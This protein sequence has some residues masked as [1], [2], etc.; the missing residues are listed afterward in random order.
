[1]SKRKPI[2]RT[3]I[4]CLMRS[5]AKDNDGGAYSRT[6]PRPVV[7]QNEPPIIDGARRFHK[8]PQA[9]LE[10]LTGQLKWIVPILP[11]EPGRRD[12]E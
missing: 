8:R 12:P 7:G 2:P 9:T 4:S 11:P 3:N 1:V 6:I 5:R 10:H